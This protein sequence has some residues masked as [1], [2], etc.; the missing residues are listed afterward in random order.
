M[1]L[2]DGEVSVFD[3]WEWISLACKYSQDYEFLAKACSGEVQI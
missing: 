1:E 3:L 2:P